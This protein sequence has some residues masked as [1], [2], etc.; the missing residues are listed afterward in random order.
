LQRLLLPVLEA[1]AETLDLVI[2]P[3][4]LIPH[5]PSWSL[6]VGAAYGF[7]SRRWWCED[8]QQHLQLQLWSPSSFSKAWWL[9]Q[10]TT[11]LA[12]A[13]CDTVFQVFH[14]F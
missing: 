9:P 6:I 5:A 1:D 11:R 4:L 2:E 7:A 12:I 8:T 14:A 3:L 10:S 13:A